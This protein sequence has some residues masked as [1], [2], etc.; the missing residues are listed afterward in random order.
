MTVKMRKEKK[1]YYQNLHLGRE[2]IYKMAHA[3]NFNTQEPEAAILP[4]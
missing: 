2:R 4:I 1:I 3:N